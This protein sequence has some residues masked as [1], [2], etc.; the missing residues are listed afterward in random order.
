MGIVKITN[1]SRD[2]RVRIRVPVYHADMKLW[3][4]P[5]VAYLAPEEEITLHINNQHIPI[6]LEE[7]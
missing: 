6:T 5:H 2:K 4:E 3:D 7:V 1:I